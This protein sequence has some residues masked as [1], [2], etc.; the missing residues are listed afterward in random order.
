MGLTL[1]YSPSPNLMD[2]A[3]SVHLPGRP[4]DFSTKSSGN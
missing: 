3:Q 2:V 1:P 4:N